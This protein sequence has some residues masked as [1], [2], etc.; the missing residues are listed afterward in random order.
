MEKVFNLKMVLEIVP[1]T[2][3]QL[4]SEMKKGKLLYKKVGRTYLIL[5][6]NLEAWL[7][8][9]TQPASADASASI[10]PASAPTP[11]RRGRPPKTVATTAESVKSVAPVVQPILPDPLQPVTE[12]P[13]GDIQADILMIETEM[14]MPC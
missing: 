4:K 14:K 1:L 12:I 5:E 10:Q 9:Y 11:K 2:E 3:G 13:P 8:D 6:K 7:H